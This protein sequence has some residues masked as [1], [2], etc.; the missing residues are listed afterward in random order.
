[1]SLSHR[2]TPEYGS[3]NPQ[4]ED[5]EVERRKGKAELGRGKEEGRWER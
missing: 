4:L 3:L 2:V 5:S 1:M